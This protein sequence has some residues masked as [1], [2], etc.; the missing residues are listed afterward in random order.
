VNDLNNALFGSL[1]KS[2]VGTLNTNAPRQV[3]L[4]VKFIW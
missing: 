4:G 3:Q 2:T 1:D